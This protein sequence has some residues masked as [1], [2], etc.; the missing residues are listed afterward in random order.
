MTSGYHN[1]DSSSIER[2]LLALDDEADFLS[3]EITDK[4][5]LTRHHIA[6]NAQRRCTTDTG[7]ISH[8]Q[9]IARHLESI[10]Q[11]LHGN[12]PLATAL[13]SIGIASLTT[14]MVLSVGDMQQ[15]PAPSMDMRYLDSAQTPHQ[16]VTQTDSPS[17]QAAAFDTEQT[18][19]LHLISSE[20]NLDLVGSVDF[21]LWLEAQQG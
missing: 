3:P 10:G 7:K 2:L 8:R 19:H 12:R 16:P 15:N 18:D 6:T 4:L 21:L 11:T 17:L 14:L 5:A 20:E 9:R 1:T 13:G